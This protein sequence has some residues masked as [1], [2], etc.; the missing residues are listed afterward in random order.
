MKP[1]FSDQSLVKVDKSFARDA[2]Y[3]E[4]LNAFFLNLVTLKVQRRQPLF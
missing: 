1:L 3:A 4:L 2:K